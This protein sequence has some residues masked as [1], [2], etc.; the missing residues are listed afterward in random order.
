MKRFSGGESSVEFSQTAFVGT[1]F[2]LMAAFKN[3]PTP[4]VSFLVDYDSTLL[5]MNASQM[6]AST[7]FEPLRMR[8]NTGQ[9][10]STFSRAALNNHGLCRLSAVPVIT[11]FLASS[12]Y[13]RANMKRQSRCTC[14]RSRS[15][16]R[17]S[18]LIT[19]ILLLVSPTG[20]T[21]CASR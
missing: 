16:R 10:P 5:D 13:S 12:L 11:P 17:P 6:H 9:F 20:P 7:F 15:W 8:R 4:A 14:E 18:A 21:R 3:V 19:H 2:P 1:G